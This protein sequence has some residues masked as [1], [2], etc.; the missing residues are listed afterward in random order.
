MSEF[1]K[2][3]I[4]RLLVSAGRAF[5]LGDPNIRARL[6]SLHC[7]RVLQRSDPKRILDAG[8]G[9]SG[10]LGWFGGIAP[11]A[12][13]LSVQFPEAM[14]V[15]LDQ[16]EEITNHNRDC[17]A[18]GHL[19]N[20]VFETGTIQTAR[21]YGTFDLVVFSDIARDAPRDSK[22]IEDA[23][24]L[25]APGGALVIICPTTV[26]AVWRSNH[27][28]AASLG[29][30]GSACISDFPQMGSFGLTTLRG[31]IEPC[32]PISSGT[33][34]GS[35]DARF[36]RHAR[37]LGDGRGS[38]CRRSEICRMRDEEANADCANGGH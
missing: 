38:D 23:A 37:E 18:K 6:R 2:D 34:P 16:Y 22:L 9:R 17:A 24:S 19:R 35:H 11:I 10:E 28:H 33:L 27:Q 14:V 21:K 32:L 29:T 15:G 12:F 8:C 1:R 36:T 25:V 7:R 30:Q 5:C 31:S 13:P 20:M 26:R 4:S 3:R